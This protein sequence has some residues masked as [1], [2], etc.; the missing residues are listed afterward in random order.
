MN[1]R[2]LH[3]VSIMMLDAQE[4]HQA[5]TVDG[6]IAGEIIEKKSFRKNYASS[7]KVG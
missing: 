2:K 4:D 3:T 5:L 1:G 7:H 6:N